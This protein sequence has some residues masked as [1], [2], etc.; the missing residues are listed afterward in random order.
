MTIPGHPSRRR[1]RG[2][3]PFC[4]PF[5]SL[6]SYSGFHQLGECT[7]D[8]RQP[9]TGA[10]R[11]EAGQWGSTEGEDTRKDGAP[12]PS[13]DSPRV[14]AWLVDTEELCT[15]LCGLKQLISPLGIPLSSQLSSEIENLK[16]PFRVPSS[17]PWDSR[18]N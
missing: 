1:A 11:G 13:Q 18:R 5:L 15:W 9:R 2:L 10:Q 3:C 12:S 6:T 4:H 16:Q 7:A 14:S 8:A 17:G